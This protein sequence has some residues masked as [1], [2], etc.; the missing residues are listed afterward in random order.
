MKRAALL[1][2]L[3]VAACQQQAGQWYK[4]GA[5]LEDF[6]R[7]GYECERD[8]RNVARSFGGGIMGQAEAEG[9]MS[10]CMVAKGWV[11]R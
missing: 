9:F 5:T 2:L 6:N 10:R 11:Y 8:T 7:D 4:T 1:G 3:A